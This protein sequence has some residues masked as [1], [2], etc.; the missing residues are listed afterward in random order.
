MLEYV[1]PEVEFVEI[2]DE[3]IVTASG[4]NNPYGY[5]DITN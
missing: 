5:G 2:E 1:K 3:D 4:C